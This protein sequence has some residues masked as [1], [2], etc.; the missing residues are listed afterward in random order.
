[1]KSENQFK[2]W[3]KNKLPKRILA[4]RLQALGDT[5]IALSYLQY[6]LLAILVFWGKLKFGILKSFLKPF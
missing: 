4:I 3:D 2:V 1:M 5:F 6:L